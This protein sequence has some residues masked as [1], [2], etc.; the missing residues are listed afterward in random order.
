MNRLLLLLFITVALILIGSFAGIDILVSDS[1]EENP[2][3]SI[4]V[5]TNDL[6][7][8]SH[9]TF[10]TY[11]SDDDEIYIIS[12]PKTQAVSVIQLEEEPTNIEDFIQDTSFEVAINA[13]FFLEDYSHAGL[14]ILEGDQKSLFSPNEPQL[15]HTIVFEQDTIEILPNSS[16]DLDELIANQKTAFQTG[17]LVVKDNKIQQALI[18]QSYNGN[19]DTKRTLIGYDDERVYFVVTRKVYTLVELAEILISYEIFSEN[20]KILNLDGGSSSSMYIKNNEQFQINEKRVLPN[21]IAF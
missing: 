14:L 15:T 11:F 2:P 7:Q 5:E 8:T 4:P 1:N 12:A 10:T 17:P 20:H 3:V 6:E 9:N 16:I 18:N 21:F 19:E 13:G